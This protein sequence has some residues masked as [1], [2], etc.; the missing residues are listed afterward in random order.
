V[1]KLVA[2]NQ[3]LATLSSVNSGS[4]YTGRVLVHRSLQCTIVDTSV[5]RSQ[6]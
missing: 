5:V 2:K 3:L 6:E 4:G 1:L